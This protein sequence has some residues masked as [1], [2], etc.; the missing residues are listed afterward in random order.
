MK[1]LII[2]DDPVIRRTLSRI[3]AR[4]EHDVYVAC[5]GKDGTDVFNNGRCDLVITD[6]IMPRQGGIETIAQIRQLDPA[7]KIIAMSGGNRTMNTDSLTSAVE[8]GANDF[9]AK[10]FDLDDLLKKVSQFNPPPPAR[11]GAPAGAG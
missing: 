9:I 1:I 3:L 5:D 11:A 10:P 7:V 2:D 6:L 4:E 8:T